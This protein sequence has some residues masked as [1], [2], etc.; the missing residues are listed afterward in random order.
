MKPFPSVHLLD[1]CSPKQWK[2]LSSEDMTPSG[3]PVYGANGQIGHYSEY[4]HEEPTLMFTC[5]GATCGT[6]N[7]SVP[8]SYIG[9]N[10]RALDHLDVR[11]VARNYLYH[12]LNYRGFR[13]AITGAAQPQ[14]TRQNLA[15]VEIPLPSLEELR[16]I[17]AILDEVEALRSKRKHG[18]DLL[19]S[20]TKS[21]FL[22][23]FGDP[24]T[25]K[26]GWSKR[27]LQHL[28]IV[29]TG[30]TPPTSDPNNFGNDV[31]FL[32]PADL[33]SGSHPNRFVSTIGATYLRAVLLAANVVVMNFDSLTRH[34]LVSG[35]LRERELI[36]GKRS[37]HSA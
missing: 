3:Y 12:C 7:L 14:I 36:R 35:N 33:E 37:K 2:T 31:P 1:I 6:I 18:L 29:H 21:I 10:A 25:D 4:T 22:E 15:R 32:T 17:A 20:L 30:K 8:F 26:K 9:G 24:R 27:S 23:M 13:D 34:E 11:R 5:R 19:N 28:G 16:H